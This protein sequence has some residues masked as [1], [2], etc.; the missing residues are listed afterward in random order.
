[1]TKKMD[2]VELAVPG[3]EKMGV[4]V[5][6]E[7]KRTKYADLQEE[8]RKNG[9]I[10]QIW[11]IKIGHRGFPAA[12]TATFFKE[13]GIGGNERRRKLKKLRE[14]ANSRTIWRCRHFKSWGS[15]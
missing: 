12:S 4:H 3:E 2:I 11:T 7:L 8:G 15:N 9:W 1:M 6:A 14:N 10:V 5:S 13:I